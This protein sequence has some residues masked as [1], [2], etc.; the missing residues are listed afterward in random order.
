MGF[1]T[2]PRLFY[3]LIFM[4]LAIMLGMSLSGSFLPLLA[5]DLDPSGVLVGLVVSAWF[6][7]RIFME[8]PAGIISD[9]IGRRKLFIFGVGLSVLG[10]FLCAQARNVYMLILG[11][12]VWGFGAALFF[13]NSTAL[14]IDLFESRTRAKALGLFNGVESIG[15]VIGAPIGAFLVSVLGYYSNVFY[16]TVVLISISLILSITSKSF[17]ETKKKSRGEDPRLPASEIL[18]SLRSWGIITICIYNFTNALVWSGLF[19]TILQLYFSNDLQ[20]PLE[21]TSLVLSARTIGNITA[22]LG[23]GILSERFGRQRI[24]AVGFT[25]SAISLFIFA[26][27]SNLEIFIVMALFESL[28]ESLSGNTLTVLLAD[29]APTSVRGG[30]I[31]L[32]RTFMDI[33]GF[34]GPMALIIVY[35]S[36]GSRTAFLAGTLVEI[37]NIALLIIMRKKL[38][39]R[40]P[41]QK[42]TT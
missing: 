2:Y 12:G 7:S 38:R 27:S 5:E 16:V 26:V 28:G 42:T 8:V 13:M 17:K 37:L 33:G 11:R 22:A 1:R 24:I 19:S 31:G 40:E 25:I 32:Q 41:E 21:Y 3:E 34:T 18:R 30:A 39:V 6:L 4:G 29:I 20:F 15:N 35:E 36:L 10:S 14:V 9:R 23:S